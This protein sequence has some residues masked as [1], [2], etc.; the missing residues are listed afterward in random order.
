MGLVALVDEGCGGAETLPDLITEF[1]C[2]GAKVLPLLMEL[3]EFLEGL[4]YI[5]ILCKG[6]CAL[7]ESGF[8]LKVLLE[9]KVTE[10]TV[11]IYKVIELCDKELIC[12]IDVTE[13][14][15]GNGTCL[16]PAVLDI[17]ELGEGA[18]N[19]SGIFHKGFELLYDALLYLEVLLTLGILLLIVFGPFLLIFY[20]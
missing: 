5:L 6:L 3:L 4:N 19:V 2:H 14:L 9:V 7:A 20:V 11:D 16:P 10:L 15:L 17:A 1:L 8:G 12:V 13:I 18:A